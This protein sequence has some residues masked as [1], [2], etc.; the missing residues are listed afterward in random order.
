MRKENHMKSDQSQKAYEK[1]I[2]DA[3]RKIEKIGEMEFLDSIP[4]DDE[5]AYP[6]IPFPYGDKSSRP[7]NFG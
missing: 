4:D 3:K 1:T 7:Y 2:E 5:R 6:S